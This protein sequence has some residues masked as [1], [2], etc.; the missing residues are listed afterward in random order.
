[1]PRKKTLS[2][3]Q[4][5]KEIIKLAESAGVQTNYFFLTTFERYQ[6]QIAILADLKKRIDESD[7]LV[8]KEYVKG[9]ENV[10]T[11]PA[12]TEY[13]KTTDSANKTVACLIKIIKGFKGEGN[14]EDIDPLVSIINGGGDNDSDDL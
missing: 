12:I 9:R 11:N 6:T 14:S 3:E 8:T 4:Q 2:L 13:N 10:Y 5:A 7:T 1:M